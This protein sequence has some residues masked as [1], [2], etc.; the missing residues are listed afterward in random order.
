MLRAGRGRDGPC[1]PPPA[2]IRTSGFPASG[3]SLGSSRH[4]WVPSAIPLTTQFS[5]PCVRCMEAGEWHCPR[6]AAFP[7]SPPPRFRPICSEISPVLRS[8]P[9]AKI[10]ASSATVASFPTRSA[11]DCSRG[12][13]HARRILALPIG[14]VRCVCACPGLRPRRV[15]LALASTG[16]AAWPSAR[17]NRVGTRKLHPYF[18]AHYWAY[19]SSVNASRTPLLPLVHDSRPGWLARPSLLGTCTPSIVPVLIGAP[20]RPGHQRRRTDRSGKPSCG[21]WISKWP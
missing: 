12:L 10:R 4:L 11:L 17:L 2:Q 16:A 13:L 20:Q 7:P 6:A 15:C 19:T 1:E 9:T 18:G 21:L 14:S 5:R 3:S 8:G